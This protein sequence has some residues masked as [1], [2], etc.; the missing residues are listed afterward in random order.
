M[1]G[2]LKHPRTLLQEADK[3]YK[4]L[5]PGQPVGLRHAGYIITVQNVIKVRGC[6][7][8]GHEVG[9]WNV[10]TRPCPSREGQRWSSRAGCTVRAQCV[11]ALCLPCASQWGTRCPRTVGLGVQSLLSDSLALLLSLRT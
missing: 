9:L 7:H 11:A 8:W 4:R 5:A 6:G 10:R 1:L 2:P 3:G